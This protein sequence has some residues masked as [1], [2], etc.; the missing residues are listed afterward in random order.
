M[1]GAR[2]PACA[3]PPRP[4]RRPTTMALEQPV[5][6]QPVG[7]VH[8][9]SGHLA[10]GEQSRELGAPLDIGDHTATAV[11]R[12]RHNRNQFLL[13]IDARRAARGGGSREPACDARDP[14]SVEVDAPIAGLPKS[15]LD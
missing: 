11:M 9:G 7:A 12:P 5:G 2:V 15:R 4:A 13:W 3:P 10:G 8:S 14:A 6:R 1:T